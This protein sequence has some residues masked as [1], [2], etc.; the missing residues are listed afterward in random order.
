MRGPMDEA[1]EAL[2][3]VPDEKQDEIARAVMQVVGIEQ[4]I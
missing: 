3:R 2:R 4:P 1:M